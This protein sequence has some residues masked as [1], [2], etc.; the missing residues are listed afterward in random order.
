MILKKSIKEMNQNDFAHF[1]KS[2]YLLLAVVHRLNGE[3]WNSLNWNRNDCNR[4]WNIVF[5]SG[6]SF[7]WS[8]IIVHVFKS[9]MDYKWTMDCYYRYNYFGGWIVN[10]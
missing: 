10:V 7:G 3:T 5:S 9:S 8:L 4:F 6:T 2:L 1:I